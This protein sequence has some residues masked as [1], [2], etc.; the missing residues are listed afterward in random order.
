MMKILSKLEIEGNFLHVIKVTCEKPTA[1]IV[2]N[3]E[4]L[5]AFT[6]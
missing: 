6:L 4:R 2:L 3:S 1:S 5:K